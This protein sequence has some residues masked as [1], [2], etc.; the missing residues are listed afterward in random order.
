MSRR[1]PSTVWIFIAF[2]PWIAYWS[3]SGP[4]LI[5]PDVLAALIS[6][7]ALNAYR[8]RT[9]N[10]KLMDAV[11]L[12]FFALH[13]VFTA[14]LRSDLF[15]TYGGVLVYLALALMAW[16]SLAFRSPFTY[17]YALDDWPREYWQDRLFRLT[18][19]VITLLWA[20]IFTLG[21]ALNLAALAP[22]LPADGFSARWTQAL[23]FDAGTYRFVTTTD[24][25]G[26]LWVDG[27]LLID[28]WQ[29]MR[30]T[31][32]ATIRLETGLHQ[33]RMEYF[34]RS[35]AALARLTWYRV[36]Q[37]VAQ[38][39]TPLSADL[40]SNHPLPSSRGPSPY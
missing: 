25:G 40:S 17:Q 7:L 22:G 23:S 24:D 2:V 6:A 37:P 29:P 16:G 27:R 26:R 19:E 39:T 8:L 15:L 30:S 38:P 28:A 34:E 33:V 1:V 12:A 18:N 3:L 5:I 10:P 32:A 21:V 9:G 13:F 4:G 35:G 11:T 20:L 36:A 14:I 31:R